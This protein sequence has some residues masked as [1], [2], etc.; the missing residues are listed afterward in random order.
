MGDEINTNPARRTITG[1]PIHPIT[2]P[3]IA[4]GRL[5]MPIFLN[6]DRV[7]VEGE[8]EQGGEFFIL[9]VAPRETTPRDGGSEEPE[10]HHGEDHQGPHEDTL[11]HSRAHDVAQQLQQESQL[12]IRPFRGQGDTRFEI[13]V[14]PNRSF[15][16][17]DSEVRNELHFN[18]D[19]LQRLR[20]SYGDNVDFFMVSCRLENRRQ[21]IFGDE[22]RLILDGQGNRTRNEQSGTLHNINT[23]KFDL[24]QD[25]AD[26]SVDITHWGG[27][28]LF[29]RQDPEGTPD[30]LYGVNLADIHISRRNDAFEEALLVR[31]NN[32]D[33]YLK[34]NNA[35][36]NVDAIIEWINQ[37]YTAGHVDW[38]M[39]L[40]DNVEYDGNSYLLDEASQNL[41]DS[42]HYYVARAV[43]RM[44]P[45]VF[46][47]LGNHDVLPSGY[48]AAINSNQNLSF[49]EA[50]EL[51]RDRYPDDDM[52]GILNFVK[53]TVFSGVNNDNATTA[54]HDNTNPF[55]DFTIDFGVGDPG[56]PRS[57]QTQFVFVNTGGADTI[58]TRPDDPL[59]RD[60]QAW[61]WGWDWVHFDTIWEF[62]TRGSPD[63]HGPTPTQNAWLSG[64]FNV[65]DT[66]THLF[67]HAPLLSSRSD[68]SGFD[69]T[70]PI[71]PMEP[72]G[73][74]EDLTFNTMAHYE[75]FF[76]LVTASPWVRTVWGGHTHRDLATG[77]YAFWNNLENN[78]QIYRGDSRRVL[79]QL[80]PYDRTITQHYYFPREELEGT[81]PAGIHT[82]FGN[83]YSDVRDLTYTYQ[84]GTAGGR[85]P[86]FSRVTLNP[87]GLF[88]GE[89][90]HYVNKVLVQDTHDADLYH[91]R[92][93]VESESRPHD[94]LIDE[95]ATLRQS[96]PHA[97]LERVRA[98]Q[99]VRDRMN[100][101]EGDL[102]SIT[103]HPDSYQHDYPTLYRPL[104]HAYRSATK[105]YQQ[106]E[107]RF[108]TDYV[109]TVGEEGA[110]LSGNSFELQLSY[111]FSQHQ[112][113]ELVRDLL[114]A[115]FRTTFGRDEA[116]G[117]DPGRYRLSFGIVTPDIFDWNVV[118]HLTLQAFSFYLG[119]EITIPD[120][121]GVGGRLRADVDMFHLRYLFGGNVLTPDEGPVGGSLGLLC[122]YRRILS[123]D[124][125]FMCGLSGGLHW[126]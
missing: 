121:G 111:E 7:F 38:V 5:G 25:F 106:F 17:L 97:T 116:S 87:D 56:N 31:M 101:S 3:E 1:N 73:P 85:R 119:P 103:R 95:W 120:E 66:H 81:C 79:D 83:H 15:H 100:I 19:D 69:P 77:D 51:E 24:I 110:G 123:S 55:S 43:G 47:G 37:E 112:V 61:F 114:F 29:D 109:P 98:L 30:Y 80:N 62:I 39:V 6:D 49:A 14:D 75:D 8:G 33:V 84:M 94:R 78:L 10:C 45:P 89:E 107:T 41:R 11:P 28:A 72:A 64:R 9:V 13:T 35:N 104:T 88:S 124:Q 58:H 68:Q 52:S 125:D 26:Q 50:M 70:G 86:T 16:Y 59:Y 27:V 65:P 12:Y 82:L 115:G 118:D 21:E 91:I 102:A 108:L 99:T 4:E 76:A 48:P 74:F 126:K 113:N 71:R 2:R 40:G 32:E 54:H 34:L 36:A 90:L 117:G 53:D 92:R 23:R 42:N 105:W 67:M 96:N 46:V 122:Q 57:R 93:V 63:T 22:F 18:Q 44:L 20:T 60:I